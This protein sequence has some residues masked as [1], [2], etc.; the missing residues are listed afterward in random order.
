MSD[1]PLTKFT[2]KLGSK[3]PTASS[4]PPSSPERAREM[5]DEGREAYD[6]Q[7]H[8]VRPVCIELRCHGSGLSHS[9][10]YAHLGVI[11]FNFRTGGELFFTGSGVAV[12]IKGRN[13]Q[14]IARAIRLHVCDYIQDHSP[15]EAR[16]GPPSDPQ[17]AFV[18]SIKVEV[19][20]GPPTAKAKEAESA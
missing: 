8:K 15:E 13:L 11:T 20:R 9:I 12:T 6:A 17:A 10:P 3:S 4:K 14:E 7:G 1:D 19:L 2:G 18:E 16:H 5:D